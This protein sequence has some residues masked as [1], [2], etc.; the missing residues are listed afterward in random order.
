MDTTAKGLGEV[1]SKAVIGRTFP[2]ALVI[3]SFARLQA[4]RGQ[5]RLCDW[6]SRGCAGIFRRCGSES[7]GLTERAS[8]PGDMWQVS[9]AEKSSALP[10]ADWSN[11]RT[12][13]VTK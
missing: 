11:R 13:I 12:G 3:T 10:R 1:L 2:S 5:R 8:H 4:P 7:P 9:G 6:G